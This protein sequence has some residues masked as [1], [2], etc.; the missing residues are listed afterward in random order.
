MAINRKVAGSNP[1]ADKAEKSVVLHLNK[2]VNPTVPQ[3][4]MK[5]MFIKATLRTSLIQRVWFKCG[6]HI[7]V[8]QLTRYDPSFSLLLKMESVV[9]RPFLTAPHK[10]GWLPESRRQ[11]WANSHEP[12]TCRPG[13]QTGPGLFSRQLELNLNTQTGSNKKGRE[14]VSLAYSGRHSCLLCAD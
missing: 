1:R 9:V 13:K 12:G 7:S 14:P 3:A 8:L 10:L 5:W 4:L 6:I 11:S 2:A